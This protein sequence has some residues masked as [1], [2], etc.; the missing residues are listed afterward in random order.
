MLSELVWQCDFLSL[1][2]L[3]Q[4]LTKFNAWTIQRFLLLK[5]L[6]YAACAI[7][8]MAQ[9][10]G[11]KRKGRSLLFK[12]RTKHQNPWHIRS[13]HFSNSLMASLSTSQWHSGMVLLDAP[14]LGIRTHQISSAKCIGIQ[15][16][17]LDKRQPW[18][19][20]HGNSGYHNATDFNEKLQDD[21]E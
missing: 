15:V 4:S 8:R 5:G 3:M 18:N 2:Y 20:L 10:S 1:P 21:D 13:F 14:P 19:G 12:M 9:L 17:T 6:V 16:V 7:Q 11:I